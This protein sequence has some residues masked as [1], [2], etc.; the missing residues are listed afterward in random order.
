MK[1]LIYIIRYLGVTGITE[2]PKE[3]NKLKVKD[4]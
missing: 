1:L 3:I 4:L 2:L